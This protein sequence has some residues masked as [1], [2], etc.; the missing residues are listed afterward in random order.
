L[1]ICGAIWTGNAP[2][3]LALNNSQNLQDIATSFTALLAWLV[4][5]ALFVER[6]V[7]V[8]V[9]VVRDYKA[10]SLD[11]QEQLAVGTLTDATAYCSMAGVDPVAAKAAVDQKR[12]AL[13]VVR[14]QIVDYRAGTKQLAMFIGFT[15]GVLLSFAGVHAL[16]GILAKDVVAGP[17]F[18]TLDVLVTGAVIAGGSEGIHRMA[19][20]FTSTM[21]GLSARGDQM[22][23][24]ANQN[25]KMTP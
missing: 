23:R 10:E 1:A 22:Q 18:K 19:N 20:A 4:I 11:H 12:Q 5:V 9:M 17:L 24:N 25:A 15:V 8:I 16:N 7:E 21:D 6:A 14:E 3:S 2:G 13:A